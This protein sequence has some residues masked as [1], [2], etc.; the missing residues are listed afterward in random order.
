[1]AEKITTLHPEGKQGVN[2]S[3]E[4]YE[5]MKQSIINALK[6]HSE[7]TFYQLND[8]VSEKLAGK[9]A[10]S[11]GWYCT[12]VKLDL[13]GRKVIQ[14]IPGSKPQRIRLVQ[15]SCLDL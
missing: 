8:A 15:Q 2:I 5:M 6:E 11:I 10:G 3:E 14:R 7:M 4:K 1:M 9:F 13:E 12:T